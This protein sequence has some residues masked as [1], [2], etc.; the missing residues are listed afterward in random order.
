MK[1]Q[2]ELEQKVSQLQ[3]L[4]HNM[5][6]ILIQKQNIQMQLL[7][8]DN[9]LNELGN[10]KDEPYK[11]VGNIMIKMEK[12]KVIKDLNSKKEMLELKLKRVDKQEDELRNK[13]SELQQDILKD[14]K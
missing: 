9:A 1:N 7:E 3:I 8:I 5:Q 12:A 10:L 6:N 11:I 14:M 2:K 4:E 13:A